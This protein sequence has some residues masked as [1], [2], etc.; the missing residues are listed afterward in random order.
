MS[1]TRKA[2]VM[3]A[4]GYGQF[5]LAMVR[6]HPAACQC[7]L[8]RLGTRPYGLWLASGELLG[9]AGMI[10]LG[11]LGVLPWLLA[12]ADGAGD[13]DRLRRLVVSGLAVGIAVA[14]GFGAVAALLWRPLPSLLWLTSDDRSLIVAPLVLVVLLTAASYPLRVF[15]AVLGGFQDV[16]FNGALSIFQSALTVTITVVLLLRG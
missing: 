13:R 14:V 11:I 7:V 16:A 5:G 10:D 12:E 1:R 4:F 6:R 9:Y 15:R 3:A 8:S 2:A